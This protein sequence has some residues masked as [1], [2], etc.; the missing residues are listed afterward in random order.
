MSLIKLSNGQT[1]NFPRR[2]F[3]AFIA[4]SYQQ[5]NQSGFGAE[6]EHIYMVNWQ[7]IYVNE[8][9]KNLHD[10]FINMLAQFAEAIAEGEVNV[11]LETAETLVRII[12]ADLKRHGHT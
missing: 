2:L 3:E 9:P 1:Q 11:H 8:I 7:V 5:A 12:L 6:V 4:F 10:E